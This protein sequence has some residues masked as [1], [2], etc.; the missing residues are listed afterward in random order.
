VVS[1][2]LEF[3]P[4]KIESG[5]KPGKISRSSAVLNRRCPSARDAPTRKTRIYGK[6]HFRSVS[7][8]GGTTRSPWNATG[9]NRELAAHPVRADHDRSQQLPLEMK[10]VPSDTLSPFE[11]AFMGVIIFR[12]ASFPRL[13]GRFPTPRY[14]STRKVRP[15]S[16]AGNRGYNCKS[17]VR[18]V[19]EFRGARA[20]AAR[21]RYAATP[22]ARPTKYFIRNSMIA[23]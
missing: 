5:L 17:R 8:C 12:C 4:A 2:C 22:S 11:Q 19:P 14:Q 3:A 23:S 10:A 16:C 21:S 1:A 15:A 13:S 7:T 9:Q 18:A 20:G 6:P